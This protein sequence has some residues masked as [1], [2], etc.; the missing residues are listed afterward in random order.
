MMISARN[1]IDGLINL[2]EYGPNSV[3]VEL[4]TANGTRMLASISTTSAKAMQLQQGDRIVAFFQAAHVLI[5]TGWAMGISARNKLDGVIET[6]HI[7]SVNSEIVVRLNESKDRIGA[8]ITNEAVGELELKSGDVV[9]V[10]I[11][12]SDV[13]IA[14]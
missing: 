5:A 2:L 8:I 14:K 12:A 10:I 1:Q 4:E 3:L 11:K 9:V 6:L 7:G 13:M